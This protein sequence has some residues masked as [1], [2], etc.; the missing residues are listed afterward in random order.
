MK[1]F[2]LL[3]I[4]IILAANS[5]AQQLTRQDYARAV[6]FLMSNLNNKKVF[7]VNT[8]FNWFADSSGLSFGI[9]SPEGR[10]FNKVDLKKMKVEKLFEHERLAKL[11]SDS[12]KKQI[13]PTELPI[14][15]VTYVDKTHLEF[16]ADGKDY[17]LDLSTYTLSTKNK[18]ESNPM[19][20]K[21]PDGKWIAYAKDFNLYIK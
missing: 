16:N 11:L 2:H 10:Q 17:V 12:L 9:Q 21:S 8:Q 1:K 13:K 15:T 7:N 14:N 3:F 18:E 6:S 4:V 19:E 20:E 5:F